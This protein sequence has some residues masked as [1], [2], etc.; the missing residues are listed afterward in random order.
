LGRLARPLAAALAGEPAGAAR[1][2]ALPDHPRLGLSRPAPRAPQDPLPA[3][4]T[5]HD[6]RHSAAPAR[7]ARVHPR[8]M[9]KALHPR[10]VA[11]ALLVLAIHAAAV[12]STQWTLPPPIA[13]GLAIDLTITSAL[14]VYA[15]A[16][17]PGHLPA[18]VLGPVVI[19]GAAVAHAALPATP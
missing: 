9:T 1:L 3:A 10:V 5:R 12:V 2:H 6:Q 8:S 17:R 18:I 4:R 7:A 14:F 19:V 15:L 13:S 11:A 16:V